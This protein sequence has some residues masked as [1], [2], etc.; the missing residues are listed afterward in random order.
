MMRDR[1]ACSVG[2]PRA[3]T[4]KTHLTPG[5]LPKDHL[6]RGDL[7]EGGARHQG[8]QPGRRGRGLDGSRSG[9]VGASVETQVW[10]RHRRREGGRENGSGRGGAGCRSGASGRQRETE[11]DR[12]R[13]KQG[14][15]ERG[16]VAGGVKRL[17]EQPA[18]LTLFMPGPHISCPAHTFHARPTRSARRTSAGY[19]GAI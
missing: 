11:R 3:I 14:E 17:Q 18:T 15:R 4:H 10:R 19:I 6:Q 7:T 12:E 5:Q 2:P 16:G 13:A 1:S 9:R 8:R